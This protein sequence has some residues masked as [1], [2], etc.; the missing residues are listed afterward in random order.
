MDID[1]AYEQRTC[2]THGEYESKRLFG[3]WMICPTCAKEKQAIEDAER[4]TR[5]TGEETRRHNARLKNM[6]VTARFIDKT[7]DN[8][9]PSCDKAQEVKNAVAA[10]AERIL[11]NKDSGESLIFVGKPGTGKTHLAIALIYKFEAAKQWAR[12]F[13]AMSLIREIRETWHKDSEL[14]E[15]QVLDT[16]ASHDLL[17]I[18]EIGV[19]YGSE[20]EKLLFFEVLNRRYE[21]KKPTVLMSNLQLA[22]VKTHL[23]ERIFDRLKEDGGKVYVFD[24]ESQRGKLAD[25]N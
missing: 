14:S 24:W 11:E 19:Q 9:R 12:I 10:Y 7:F 1:I 15:T 25:S 22:E 18:D 5:E 3:R 13:T 16:L 20:A 4:L 23:G 8:Y 6:G 21:N 2:E 17:I